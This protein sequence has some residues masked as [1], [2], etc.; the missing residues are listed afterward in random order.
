MLLNEYIERFSLRGYPVFTTGDRAG[1]VLHVLAEQGRSC[2]PVLQD[3][4]PA[5]LVT[6]PLLLAGREGG[7]KESMSLSSFSLP[8]VAVAALHEHLLDV[9]SR[10]TSARGEIIAVVDEDG[11][12]SAVIEKCRLAREISSLF[13]LAAGDCVTI[14]LEV[15]PS[16]IRMSEVIAVLEKNDALVQ[17][18]GIKKP[19]V[20]GESMILCFRIETPDLYRLGSSLAKYGYRVRYASALA[21]SADDE[22]REK[23]LEFIRYLDM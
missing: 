3:G 8:P 14:E 21:G 9:F 1:T 11:L 7:S 6:L 20:E 13:H 16:G 2:A 18:F 4:K 17:A 19:S 15:P 22:L 12:F 10:A 23:A 5:F